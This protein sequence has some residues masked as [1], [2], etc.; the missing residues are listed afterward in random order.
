MSYLLRSSQLEKYFAGSNVLQRTPPSRLLCNSCSAVA[1]S[2]SSPSQA[3][4]G[5]GCSPLSLLCSELA[6]SES[7]WAGHCGPLTRWEEGEEA[8]LLD[9]T[10]LTL[11]E[12][13]SETLLYCQTV[14]F[15]D[16]QMQFKMLIFSVI[17]LHQ[18]QITWPSP[19]GP[20]ARDQ[21]IRFSNL[22]CLLW[23]L[24]ETPSNLQYTG[25]N[26]SPP[27][28]ADTIKQLRAV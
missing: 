23:G 26:I 1:V 4:G 2:Q 16:S 28:K 25:W 27:K 5:P 8:D 21:T 17:K 22:F 18:H 14:H 19:A 10:A 9:V 24:A 6:P 11:T 15:P 12:G 3:A 20:V 13:S 7:D